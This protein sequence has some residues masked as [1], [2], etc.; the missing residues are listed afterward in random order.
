[1]TPSTAASRTKKLLAERIQANRKRIHDW[2]SEH[3]QKA[4]PPFYCSVDLRDS[5][6]KVVPVDSNLYPA[7]FNNI[8]PEDIR[9]APP[10]LRAELERVA[11][12]LGRGKPER[13]LIL[14]ESHT[15]NV[16][17]IE[18]LHY[19]RQI[20]ADAGFEVRIGWIPEVSEPVRLV[21]ATSK[22]L[23]ADPISIAGGVLSAGDF[24]PDLI[25]LNNDFSGGYPSALDAVTQPIV[26]SHAMGW[27]TRKKSD[28]FKHYNRLAGEFAELIGIDPWLIQIETEEVTPVDFNEDVG[29]EAVA[30]AAER[31][32]EKTRKAFDEHKINRKPFVF[33]KNNAGTYGMGI[34]VVHSADELRN[35]N[36]RTKNKMSVGKNRMHIGSVAVQEGVPTATLVDRLAA[37]P[38]IYLVGCEL[39]GGFLRTNTEKG[40]EENLNSQGMV[41]RKLCM[42]DL[43]KPGDEFEPETP[44]DNE[45]ILELVYGSVARISALATGLEMAENRRKA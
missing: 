43:R 19:L 45:P 20:V 6:H 15:S 11:A 18:N 2:Y 30:Q 36:R 3:A 31:I 1:M 10:I 14:P 23:V 9:H 16:F 37:E 34:M 5:G 13:I 44:E 41:F 38:V 8:C 7:G 4:P 39:I 29:T 28:H 21:S 26:P 17:Y 25:L 22:E 42:S 40:E 35:M 33:V 32:L 24:T 12:R 27:H